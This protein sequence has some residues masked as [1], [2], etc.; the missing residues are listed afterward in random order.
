MFSVAAKLKV[1]A[2]TS[3]AGITRAPL[4]MEGVN[5]DFSYQFGILET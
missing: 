4:N 1:L 3:S 2:C 5:N